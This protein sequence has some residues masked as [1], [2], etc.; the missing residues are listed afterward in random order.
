MGYASSMYHLDL[1]IPAL[2]KALNR[3]LRSHYHQLNKEKRSWHEIM[4]AS[5][6]WKRPT[7]PLTKAKLTIVR[8]YYRTLD[9]DG[10]VGSMKPVVDGLIHAGVISDDSWGVLGQWD[11]SQ[12]FRPKKLGPLLEI[13]IREL[14]P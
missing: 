12:E 10:L 1:E 11:V 14:I 4:I 5:V 8:H 2:P 3:A 13:K 6:G 9:Y 7:S